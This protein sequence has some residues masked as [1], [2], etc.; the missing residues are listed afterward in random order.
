MIDDP[1][2][3]YLALQ[4]RDARFDGMFYVGVTSTGIYCRPSCPARTAQRRHCTFHASAAAAQQAGF[5]ACK[6]CRPDAVPGSPEWHWR[7]DV[8]GRALRLIADGVVD[9]DGVGGLAARVG[10]S[11]R[12]LQRLLQAEV[13]AGPLAL[14]RAQRARTAR[15]LLESS[16]MPIAH[17]AFAAGFASVRQFNDTLRAVFAMT[18]RELRA[19]SRN[20]RDRALL[21]SE[22]DT[23]TLRLAARAPFDA[24]E[25]LEFL[26]D[27]AIPGLEHF[28]GTTF[29]RSVVLPSGPAT[30]ALRAAGDGR[31]VVATLRLTALADLTAAVARVRRLADLD[32]DPVAVAE[33]LRRD[34][35][36]ATLV[37]AAPGRRVPGAVDGAELAIRAVVG[38]QVSVAAARTLAARIVA[39]HG[40]PHP[41]SPCAAQVHDARVSSAWVTHCFPAAEVLAV[42]DLDGLGLTRGRIRT[43]HAVADAIATGKVELDPGADRLE[44]RAR[45]VDLAGVGPWTAEYV[46]LRALGDPDAFPATDL[47]LRAGARAV[48]LAPGELATRAEAWRPWRAY[49]ALHLWHAATRHPRAGPDREEHLR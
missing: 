12:Q 5:R 39:R 47:G 24:Q 40:P 15:V 28:D 31:G 27:R 10:Y 13:G 6:R 11:E 7:G 19:A 35:A 9:R 36:L 45:L 43:I 46:A 8:V 18:P 38:Q 23:V 3:C 17:V 34:D 22:P 44:L 49:A 20:R 4:S 41:H 26:G 32:A 48:G 16:T 42:A 30:I 33:H 1:E 29:S 2:R 21:A 37:A 14:A 25:V